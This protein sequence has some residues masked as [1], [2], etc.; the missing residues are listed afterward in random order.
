[1]PLLQPPVLQRCRQLHT[2]IQ[3]H[4]AEAAARDAERAQRAAAGI[5]SKTAQAAVSFV[6]SVASSVLP[7][8]GPSTSSGAAQEEPRSLELLREAG[9][10]VEME[11][12]GGNDSDGSTGQCYCTGL[13]C[14]SQ[15]GAFL[16]T[17]TAW[18]CAT[19][20]QLVCGYGNIVTPWL[21]HVRRS[22]C[23]SST[24]SPGSSLLNPPRQQHDSRQHSRTSITQL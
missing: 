12:E 4:R 3:A 6:G 8:V 18:G 24:S 2:A 13:N 22:K 17:V 14:I 15:A 16:S 1:V 7:G 20:A 11:D 5:L 10:A 23:V 9:V 21:L 19:V